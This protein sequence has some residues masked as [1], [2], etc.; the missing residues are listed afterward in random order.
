MS[1]EIFWYLPK[2]MKN[3]FLVYAEKV[4]LFVNILTTFLLI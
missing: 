3:D 4:K 1:K 2:F